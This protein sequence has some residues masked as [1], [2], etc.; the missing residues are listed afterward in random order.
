[1]K[2]ASLSNSGPWIPRQ[3]E[4]PSPG[5]APWHLQTAG[6]KCDCQ[7]MIASLYSMVCNL[8]GVLDDVDGGVSSFSWW[9]PIRFKPNGIWKGS[10]KNENIVRVQWSTNEIHTMVK[11]NQLNMLVSTKSTA[12]AA[13][14]GAVT[15]TKYRSSPHHCLVRN[16][17]INSI[18]YF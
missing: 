6:D 3:A 5:A 12:A 17:H 1:M 8:K 4:S 2:A 14:A 7:S 16:L 13:T 9:T 11:H 18:S 10:E 15:K